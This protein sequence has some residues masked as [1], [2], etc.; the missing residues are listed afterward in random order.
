MPNWNRLANESGSITISKT[1]KTG[2]RY[3]R[4]Q[5][6][7]S[8]QDFRANQTRAGGREY[9][10]TRVVGSCCSEFRTDPAWNS[11]RNLPNQS[12]KEALC[13]AGQS[14]ET[15]D[16]H[17]TNTQFARSTGF[18]SALSPSRP[19]PFLCANR[20][21]VTILNY[22]TASAACFRLR[23]ASGVS[24]RLRFARRYSPLSAPLPARPPQT[25]A[26]LNIDRVLRRA[27]TSAKS[28]RQILGKFA[29]HFFTAGDAFLTR[30]LMLHHPT[31]KFPI[32]H[33]QQRVDDAGGFRPGCIK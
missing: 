9:P 12:C 17:V 10:G 7:A 26:P 19:R 5:A 1:R 6:D 13:D 21:L 3:G 14:G 16:S 25:E 11:W 27:K 31:A 32:C 24:L 28:L 4:D 15:L 33:R 23:R 22:W 8:S 29:C 18:R 30:L 20:V 2:T